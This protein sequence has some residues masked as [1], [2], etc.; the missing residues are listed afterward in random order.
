M[1]N[2]SLHKASGEKLIDGR[3]CAMSIKMIEK[4]DILISRDEEKLKLLK[5]AVDFF[6]NL[7]THK[8]H[9]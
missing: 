4:F 3:V 8:Y 9:L 1:G 2:I 7:A 5:L 6:S